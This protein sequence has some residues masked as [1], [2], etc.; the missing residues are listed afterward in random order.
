LPT[1]EKITSLPDEGCI[2]KQYTSCSSASFAEK[3]ASSGVEE[4]V[5]T[6]IGMCVCGERSTGEICSEK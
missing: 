5:L 1:R 2:E 3:A 6:V 4:D